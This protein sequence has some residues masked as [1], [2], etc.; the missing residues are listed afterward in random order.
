M[1]SDEILEKIE[2]LRQ[3]LNE[4][5]RKKNLLDKDVIRISKQLDD[6]FNIYQKLKM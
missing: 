3:E 6:L 4:I 1:N 5:G 2:L